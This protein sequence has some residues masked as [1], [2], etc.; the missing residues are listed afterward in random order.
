MLLS[1]LFVNIKRFKDAKTNTTQAPCSLCPPSALI[2]YSL[3]ASPAHSSN[4]RSRLVRSA[5]HVNVYYSVLHCCS[6]RKTLRLWNIFPQ[7][8]NCAT[9][10]ASIQ[11]SINTRYSFS[12]N[13]SWSIFDR[14]HIYVAWIEPYSVVNFYF[15][16]YTFYLYLHHAML[17]IER[18][19]LKG[20]QMTRLIPFVFLKHCC[21]S[22]SVAWLYI[23]KSST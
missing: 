4:S 17:L 7:F 15:F 12:V 19:W 11:R 2:G 1:G 21:S 13:Q 3:A 23:R 16:V 6:S 14:K 8:D 10:L 5:A 22:L 9:E 20:L 18:K